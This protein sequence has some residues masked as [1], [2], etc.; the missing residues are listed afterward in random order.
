MRRYAFNEVRTALHSH[1]G[2]KLYRGRELGDGEHDGRWDTSYSKTGYIVGGQLPGLGHGYRRFTTLASIV[3][4][5][6]LSTTI[7]RDRR[8]LN[9][10]S[11]SIQDKKRVD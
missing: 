5:C 11:T 3:E 10:R 1:W 8:S 4:A 2:L 6:D 9:E 7:E